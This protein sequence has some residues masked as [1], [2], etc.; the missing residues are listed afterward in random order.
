MEISMTIDNRLV[1]DKEFF[2]KKD[3]R[4]QMEEFAGF[5]LKDNHL[6]KCAVFVIA[7]MNIATEVLADTAS[8]LS[9]MDT[10]GW[11]FLSIVQ[12]LGFWVCLIGCL[13]EI[14]FAVF[15]QGKHGGSL[16]PIGL[17]WIGLFLSFY[18]LPEIFILIKELFSS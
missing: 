7:G 2:A 14:L 4:Q 5:I 8:T 16:L 6:T 1:F 15:K 3:N 13:L 18:L 9:K 10:A 12:Q 11:T 17:K